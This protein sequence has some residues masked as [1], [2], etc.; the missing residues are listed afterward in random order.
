M[1]TNNFDLY[2][3]PLINCPMFFCGAL[4]VG[5]FDEVSMPTSPEFL[6]FR[7]IHVCTYVLYGQKYIEL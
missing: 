4:E 5:Q 3:R 6:F 1:V 7:Y 2:G